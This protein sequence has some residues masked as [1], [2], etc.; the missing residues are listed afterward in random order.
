[1]FYCISGRCCLPFCGGLIRL[2]SNAS[3]FQRSV[4]F[5][6]RNI[7][8]RGPQEIH[9]EAAF[10]EYAFDSL[11]SFI[12]ENPSTYIMLSDPD[13][14]FHKRRIQAENVDPEVYREVLRKRYI[15]LGE[16]TTRIGV[17]THLFLRARSIAV[18]TFDEQC[19]LIKRNRDFLQNL[20]LP[21]DDFA[22]GWNCYNKD[23]IHACER[24]GFKRFHFFQFRQ[25]T[26]K[27]D[28]LKFIMLYNVVHDYEL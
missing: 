2:P 26:E 28:R 27:S 12:R 4:H 9:V 14:M 1:M 22:P 8:L 25:G 5:L 13:E 24:L 17:H 21:T 15:K 23:T 18:P 16:L 3:F 6:R 11:C 20:D 19:F 10:S 7:W